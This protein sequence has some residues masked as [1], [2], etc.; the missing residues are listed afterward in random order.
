M[1]KK[2]IESE[3]R[4]FLQLWPAQQMID[5]LRDIIPLFELFDVEDENDWVMDAVGPDDEQNVRLVRF[6]YLVS[7]IA[8][9]HTGRLARVKSSHPKLCSRLEEI[10]AQFK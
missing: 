8:E 1:A 5:F 4:D 7:V 3:I 10:A 2:D 6:I 9:K